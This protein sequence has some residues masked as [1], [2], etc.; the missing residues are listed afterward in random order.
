MRPLD[1]GQAALLASPYL[2][3]VTLL[4]LTTYSNRLLGAV[5][6]TRYI[7]TATRL[8]DWGNAGTVREFQ[9]WLV[10]IDEQRDTMNHVP[11]PDGSGLESTLRRVRRLRLR[12]RLPED[13]SYL[14]TTLRAENVEFATVEI[15]SLALNVP[16]DSWTDHQAFTGAEATIIYRGRVSAVLGVDDA[17]I[18]LEL[19][20]EIPALPELYI[21]DPAKSD[22]RDLGKR[23]PIV[24]G[25]AR[26]ELVGYDVGAITFLS[27]AFLTA[28]GMSL[29]VDVEDTTRFP[30]AGGLIIDKE[31][32]DYSGLTAGSIILTARA[33]NGTS[34]ADHDIGATIQLTTG[35]TTYWGVASH[36]I[37]AVTA[38]F[39]QR[40]GSPD[41]VR[42][43]ASGFTTT[44]ADTT[45]VPGRTVAHVSMTSAQLAAVSRGSG[46]LGLRFYAEVEG[47][48]AP[49]NYVAG[50]AFDEGTGWSVANGSQSSE[51]VDRTEGAAAQ[52]LTSA[53][54]GYAIRY[55]L[56][57]QATVWVA[58]TN[59]TLAD[60]HAVT[61]EGGASLRIRSTT[62]S[63]G[64]ATAQA[65]ITFAAEDW[66]GKDLIVSALSPLRDQFTAGAGF[67]I[68]A[69][70]SSGRI[71]FWTRGTTD[72]VA[73]VWEVVSIAI[74]SGAI[75]TDPGWDITQITAL[76]FGFIRGN[77]A[78]GY[79]DQ[80]Y[81]GNGGT[82]VAAM[83][84]NAT[85]GT[86][87]LTATGNAYRV[88]VKGE[89][90]VYTDSVRIYFSNV[91]G[92]GTAKPASYWQLTIP[93]SEIINGAWSTIDKVAA[94]TG[95]P[96]TPNNVETI[97]VEIIGT[98]LGKV[99][100]DNLRCA[101]AS[102]SGYIASAGTLLEK[103]PDVLRHLLT[104]LCIPPVAVES[105]WNDAGDASHLDANVHGADLRNL[106]ATPIDVLARLAFESRANLIS[107]ERSTGTIFRLQVASS[108]Y[109][110]TSSGVAL[111]RYERITEEG[112]DGR[113]IFT[114]FRTLYDLNPVLGLDS[115]AFRK[116]RLKTDATAEDRFGRH[117]AEEIALGSVVDD[118]TADEVAGYY[119]R[120]LAR[121]ASIYKV[122][123]VPWSEAY[124][125]ER[126]DV[127]TV[128]VPWEGSPVKVRVIETDRQPD[129][130]FDLRVVA[131][132]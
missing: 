112:R 23:W 43:P 62:S 88:D 70:D 101:T 77:K 42:V 93:C 111:E 95:G 64:G 63:V 22:P 28:T 127:V 35:R 105:T 132:P 81:F 37:S 80:V 50:Y 124:A 79:V 7:S 74:G 24:Y 11:S 38:L 3:E 57:D 13:G 12:N 1:A 103:M 10:A 69:E 14:W 107:D 115:E 55:A 126:G 60:E 15:A 66:T 54:A 56:D 45:L 72:F 104:E 32:F 19:E 44:L 61:R 89:G 87:D 129:G 41:L 106:G 116:V 123:G 120:E 90:L 48:L 113:T 39:V 122:E 21:D 36:A 6:T 78:V 91:A 71:R 83:Q 27:E 29:S 125:L 68:I 47:P 33:Q 59:T 109:D 30:A 102:A 82:A 20:S 94:G 131:V 4:A 98:G 108:A 18:Q 8:Y 96:A 118:A 31:E 73:G 100:V 17:E 25:R 2:A 86:V 84:R 9:P 85:T 128:V 53:A 5:Q 92:A 97:G 40:A 51:A 110:W 16:T 75:S 67:T 99:W 46:P 26:V 119:E 65:S 58:G 52:K 49:V 114:R 121:V 130:A 117:D 76:H 34:A